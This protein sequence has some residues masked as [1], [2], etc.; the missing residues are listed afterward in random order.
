MMAGAVGL[1]LLLASA[2]VANLLLARGVSHH[3][4]WSLRAALGATRGQLLRRALLESLVL[5]E[6]STRM[7]HHLG[8][9]PERDALLQQLLDQLQ[10]SSL[11]GVP[12]LQV[13]LLITCKILKTCISKF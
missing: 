3:R 1:L 7:R 4:E 5:D 9:G 11:A 6:L 2:N 12:E 13:S 10:I 8:D